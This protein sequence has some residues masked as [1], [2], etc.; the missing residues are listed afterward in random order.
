[1]KLKNSE[2]KILGYESGAQM[3][4]IGANKNQKSYNLVLQFL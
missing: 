2:H 3:G 1:M 4:S